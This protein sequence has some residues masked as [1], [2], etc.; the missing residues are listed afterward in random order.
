MILR[1]RRAYI[2]F[3]KWIKNVVLFSI[4][5]LCFFNLYGN[6]QISNPGL[7]DICID[8]GYHDLSTIT[9]QE[10][11][12]ND[13]ALQTNETLVIEFS[14]SGFEFEVGSGTIVFFGPDISAASITVTAS[15]AT[16]TITTSGTTGIDLIQISGL[17]IRSTASGSADI[18]RAASSTSVIAGLN[19]TGDI[20]TSVSS[21]NISSNPGPESVCENDVASMSIAH[22]GSGISLQW[23]EDNGGGFLPV[24]DGAVFSGSSTSELSI[25]A[26]VAMDGN[27]YR[28]VTTGAGGCTLTSSSALLSVSDPAPPTGASPQTFCTI[29]NPLVSDLIA[30]G[31]SIQWYT[32][33]TGGSPLSG[34]TALTNGTTYYASQTTGGC[35][36]SVRLAVAVTISDPSAPTGTSPQTF[37]SIDNPVVSDLAATGTNIQW[38][39]APTGGSPLAVGAALANG[40]TYYASQTPGSC[41]SSVRFAAAVTINDP[42]A[43]T[44]SATQSFCAVDNPTI[45]DI[46]VSGTNIQW[47]STP[48][49][50]SP[51]VLTTSL[52]NGTTY[53]ASQTV[54]SCESDIRLGVTVT[55]NDAATPTGSANQSFCTIDNPLVSDLIATGTSIQWYTTATGGS[56]L[57]GGTA[58]TNGTTYYASQTTGGCESSV[59][60]AVSVNVYQTPEFLIQNNLTDICHND[61]VDIEI[62]SPTSG[63]IIR[64]DAVSYG[65]ASGTY[66]GGETFT[67]GDNITETINNLTNS[68]VV[69]SYTFSATANSCP[70]ISSQIIQ[71]EVKPN[72]DAFA[73]NDIICSGEN[74]NIVITN[75]NSV[76]ETTYSWVTQNNSNVTGATADFG[77]VIEQQLTSSDGVSQ[78]TIDY[79]IT[80]SANGCSGSSITVTATVN[81]MPDISVNPLSQTICSGTSTGI[82]ISNPNGVPGTIFEWTAIA[83]PNILN[84]SDGSGSAINQNLF[85]TDNNQGS[86]TY[87]I[88]PKVGGCVGDYSDVV[89]TV[90]PIP[91]VDATNPAICNGQITNIDITNPNNVAFT[92]FSWTVQSSPAYIT[93]AT[94]GSGTEISQILNNT[95]TIDG[96]V[97]YRITPSALGCNGADMFLSQVVHPSNTVF[98]GDDQIVCDGVASIDIS[99][100]VIT[101]GATF[102]PSEWSIISGN[103]TLSDPNSIS[104]SYLPDVDETGT[105]TLQL[106]AS[107]SNTCPDV[108]DEINLEILELKEVN[109]GSDQRVC[110]GNNIFL[111][112]A[113]KGG[114]TGSV[115]WSGGSGT[116]LPNNQVLNAVYRP[117]PSEEGD[118]ITLTIS[119][120][121]PVGP[122]TPVSDDIVIIIDSPPTAYAGSDLEFCQGVSAVTINDAT[123]GGAAKFPPSVWTID[124]G[125][126][127]LAN[128]NTIS[129]TYTPQAGETGII[130]LKLTASGSVCPDAVDYV[131]V[132]IDSVPVV[133]AGVD[134]VVC[135][136]EAIPL[137]DA[138]IKGSASSVIWSGGAGSFSPNT[139]TLNAIYIP[140][141]SETNQVVTLTLTTNDPTGPCTPANSQV[142]ITI[143]ELPYVFAGSKKIICEGDSAYFNDAVMGGSASSVVWTGGAGTFVPDNTTLNARY[144]PDN[145]EINTTVTLTLTSDDPAGP[146][147]PVFSEVEVQINKAP[148]VDAGIDRIICET[149][150]VNLNGTIA[151][152][153]ISANWT[154]SGDGTFSFTG[155]LNAIYTPGNNDKL[156]GQAVL[157]LTTN[158]PVGPCVAVY[159][160]MKLQV[161]TRAVVDAGTYAPI[162]IGDTV[163]L[164]GTIGG[165]ASSASWS[166]GSGNFLDINQLNTG[167][168]PDQLEAGIQVLLTLT[169]DDPS[170]PCPAAISNTYVMV[171]TLPQPNFFGLDV[172]YQVDD[173]NAELTGFPDGGIF[174]G[175]GIIGH[176]FSPAVADTGVHVIQYTY[177][178]ANNCTNFRL[179][180][181]RVFPLP[182]VDVETP[183][184]FCLNEQMQKL[185]RTT[186]PT[187]TDSWEGSFIFQQM[188]NGKMEYY[189][190]H[191][192]AG[193]GEHYVRYVVTDKFGVT[194]KRDKY[195]IVNDVPVVDFEVQNHC[196]SDTIIFRD[197]TTIDIVTFPDGLDQ[198]KW[199][200]GSVKES[201]EQ[202][203]RIKFDYANDYSVRLEVTSKLGCSSHIT[204]EVQVG[205]VPD[206]DF[207]WENVSVG[208]DSTIFHEST[209]IPVDVPIAGFNDPTTGLDSITWDFG[210]GSAVMEGDESLRVVKHKFSTSSS[211]DVYM[212]I[213]TNLGCYSEIT[214]TISIL[215]T[216]NVYPY[217]QNFDNPGYV[218]D[219]NGDN[220]SWELGTPAGT[221]INTAYSGSNS[222][223]TRLDSVHNNNEKSFVNLSA[224]DLRELKRPMLSIAI[225]S[226]AENTRDGAVLQYSLSGGSEWYTLVDPNEKIGLNWYNEK[227]LVSR[228]GDGES[229]NG[230]NSSGYGWTGVNNEWKIARFPL[231]DLRDEQ[232]L[233]NKESVRF[234]IVFGSDSENPQNSEF[235]GF[236]F[237]DLWIGERERN[238][239][240]EHFDNLN[241]AKQINFINSLSDRMVVDMIPVQYHINYPST[242]PIYLDNPDPPNTRSSVY[243]L[244]RSP[245]SFLDGET[246]YDYDPVKIEDYDIINRALV[247]PIFD[248]GVSIDPTDE[249][250]TV[251]INVTVMARDTVNNDVILHIVPVE[252]MISQYN[253][254]GVDSLHNVVKDMLPSGG[255]HFTKN[256]SA[257][258]TE[259]VSEIWDVNEL[260]L[261][262]SSKLGVIV[263]IQN[264]INEGDN[265][266]H[267]TI[268][269]DLPVKY[270]DGVTGII[271]DKMNLKLFDEST[272]YPNPAKDQF[273]VSLD[274]YITRDM[275]WNITNQL[276]VRLLEGTFK[277]GEDA[278][279]IDTSSLPN[280]LFVFMVEAE[281][282][283][284]VIKKVLI[285]R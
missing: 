120:N 259:S 201:Y 1:L 241:G 209:I 49:G 65:A 39:S 50:G 114:S 34:G 267:Q 208:L 37:C 240:V 273:S 264:A 33:A 256:W 97:T 189:F 280:G 205:G 224:F 61:Q 113:T 175:P 168:V 261:Y 187:V 70:S 110:Y 272:I 219:V 124:S 73:D 200:F 184:P 21:Y 249:T 131:N 225:W 257:G 285:R 69:I 204:R 10:Q 36:S 220:S 88:E 51:L 59:R 4:S 283:L 18:Q 72:P 197:L 228:P 32:T 181:T 247:D 90:N 231:D 111:E 206:A 93:G 151:G 48:T 103:G 147:G 132:E 22:S 57:A 191:P 19:N 92:T 203:P 276:G 202:N 260:N 45:S 105:I 129:P 152:S 279:I 222:W 163:H 165:S 102:P 150:T 173:P 60:L 199:E 85:C 47:Y 253:Y 179:D 281:N 195:I 140:D 16:I 74:T 106:K 248:I 3:F 176:F 255:T 53:Y 235:D 236:A 144:V 98:A 24:S 126:G 270:S 221:L 12:N 127:S 154:T 122:C 104:T 213:K 185:P 56:P 20:V 216:I 274:T 41:E 9:I 42:S 54:G 96:S 25:I 87:R 28:C 133:F 138:Y 94:G 76:P 29:D 26:S 166:G 75:P 99:D 190:E 215:N 192:L 237:D 38:Y 86:V 91:D 82:T 15:E 180:S 101:G 159:D 62:T 35:E 182:V 64:L 119:S 234:R 160:S 116:F 139:S 157:Y 230:F 183:G 161:D 121:D 167:Y 7:Y 263:L 196:V 11:I 262:D 211:Y 66:S 68:S 135:E 109:A 229:I 218:I 141:V 115:I 156:N 134:K 143:N 210:D 271:E 172:A 123:I 232:I 58:L 277:A 8:G 95:S 148:E 265:E 186:D 2:V 258:D 188:E 238:V 243:N 177:T 227:G 269:L 130:T 83:T 251:G 128:E 194:V 81:P 23:E 233:G 27:A 239:L 250:N 107:S 145:S 164:S 78:G 268:Y 63:A 252:R 245:R 79:V 80:P 108:F 52:V 171:N 246:E 278:F 193:V 169:T 223:M 244:N 153:A 266:V 84:A 178:D 158:D 5:F 71:V 207:W 155:D 282:E 117:H 6:V 118:T 142:N 40:T 14:G 254:F 214:Q 89:V 55:V 125:N 136:G 30:T 217:Y 137:S 43:P 170:G 67:D 162:C 100:A 174:S 13:F 284:K 212:K 31:T 77:S 112:E 275:E 44:G 17:R 242:D 46:A 226:N 198:W 146:C 149:S